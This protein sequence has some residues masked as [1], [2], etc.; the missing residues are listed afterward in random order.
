MVQ[1]VVMRLW[2]IMCEDLKTKFEG[3]IKIET[4]EY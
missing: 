2:E 3:K 4:P 1:V